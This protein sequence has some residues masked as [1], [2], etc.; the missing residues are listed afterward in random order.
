[1]KQSTR[2]DDVLRRKI[3]QLLGE[4]LDESVHADDLMFDLGMRYLRLTAAKKSRPIQRQSSSP[5]GWTAPLRRRPWSIT[6]KP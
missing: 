2:F 5:S 1:M 6:S 4:E 3:S